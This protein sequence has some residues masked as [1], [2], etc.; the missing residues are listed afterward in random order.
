MVHVHKNKRAALWQREQIKRFGLAIRVSYV[1]KFAPAQ[2]TPL[3]AGESSSV[4]DLC[5]LFWRSVITVKKFEIKVCRV[6]PLLR[7]GVCTETSKAPCWR[8]LARFLCSLPRGDGVSTRARLGLERRGGTAQ[9]LETGVSLS[10]ASGAADKLERGRVVGAAD[11]AEISG[12][13]AATAE[14][15]EGGAA[16]ARAAVAG[17]CWTGR[18]DSVS[19]RRRGAELETVGRRGDRTPPVTATSLPERATVAGPSH[20]EGRRG[21][22]DRTPPAGPVATTDEADGG[23]TAS[24]RVRGGA[25]VGNSGII[26][27][28]CAANAD[29]GGDEA[30]QA[31]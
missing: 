13:R 16:T 30:A 24:T 22:G 19:T 11:G 2:C 26:P 4:S 14:K 20:I 8:N 21:R 7:S 27:S 18:G 15:E 23:G 25:D 29:V 5:R 12:H 9:R 31:G 17:L 28:W 1:G 3:G 6:R 10:T